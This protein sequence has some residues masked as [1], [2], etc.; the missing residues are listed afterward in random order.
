[1]TKNYKSRIIALICEKIYWCI[2]VPILGRLFRLLPINDNKVLFDNFGGKGFA[3]N[4]KYI[5][6]KLADMHC[7]VKMIWLIANNSRYSF[8]KYISAVK[9][10]SIR[11][12]YERATS[13]VWVD[14]IR[15]LH[16]V[17]KR[18]QQIYLQTWHGAFPLKRIEKDAEQELGK[19]YCD[20]AKYDGSITDGI[21]VGSGLLEEQ[22]RR[23]FWLNSKT[24]YLRFGLP[25]HDYLFNHRFDLKYK[26]ELRNK[27]GIDHNT[28]MVLYAPTFRDDNS[29]DGYQVDFSMVLGAFQKI[30]G[31]NIKL[32]VRFHPNVA[33]FSKSVQ[34][35]D[36]II[37]GS[38]IPD[39]QELSIISDCVITDYSSSLFDFVILNKPVYICA[40]D[41]QH[42]DKLR[43]LLP[44]YYSLPFPIATTNNELVKNI[45]ECDEVEY[46]KR[47]DEY[48]ANYPMYDKGNASKLAADWICQKM[49]KSNIA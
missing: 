2:F 47:V 22:Y 21:L 10:N 9:I 46:F 13:K 7:N 45:I 34:Y 8:P 27:Y 23:A 18:K 29:I 49:G 14:N 37:N 35:T 41:L 16:P 31:K 42:Y 44:E 39:M 4:P 3:D 48:F 11:G 15:H 26:S 24:E 5:A 6:E 40:L 33:E 43:G 25:R 1:M 17:K 36:E 32:Y 19:M 28:Y 30:K 12:L 38:F 20:E